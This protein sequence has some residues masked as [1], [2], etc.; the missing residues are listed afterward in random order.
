M[1]VPLK[2]K[3]HPKDDLSTRTD[4]TYDFMAEISREANEIIQKSPELAS[5]K[6]MASVKLFPSGT[7]TTAS[8]EVVV[9]QNPGAE[10]SDAM[11]REVRQKLADRLREELPE[12]IGKAIQT[13]VTRARA[14]M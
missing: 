11:L 5:L 4:F 14:R 2:F 8:V 9:S 10:I 3:M 7:L 6:S 1:N 12:R 13:S